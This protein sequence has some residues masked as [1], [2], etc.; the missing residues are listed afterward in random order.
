[1]GGEKTIKEVFQR[2]VSPVERLFIMLAENEPPFCNQLVLEGTGAFKA[3]LWKQAVVAACE[4]NPGSRLLL[5]GRWTWARWEDCG[6]AAPIRFV[7]GLSWS[8]CASDG[9]PFLLDPFPY[10]RGHTSEVLLV[11]GSPPRVVLRTLHATMDGGGTAM[12]GLDIF[13]ALRN[14]PLVG[15]P[16][17][18][19][20]RQLVE[21]LGFQ[22]RESLTT[23]RCL[24]PTGPPDGAALG[25]KWKRTTLGGRFSKLLPQLA[26]AVAR[27]ARKQGPGNVRITVPLD[28]RKRVPG[29]ASTANL[30]RRIFLDIPPEATV[31][32][33]ARQ[34]K[35]KL[36]HLTG[37]PWLGNL[38]V[39]LPMGWLK[40][41]FIASREKDRVRG[42]YKDSG[43]ISNLGQLPLDMFHGGGF[44]ARSCFFIPP[45]VQAK[46]FFITLSGCG[47][48][49]EMV[50]AM[51]CVLA[52]NGRLERFI[53]NIVSELKPSLTKYGE[54]PLAEFLESENLKEKERSL[55]VYGTTET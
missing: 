3:A 15:A 47:D 21:G 34:L 53:A 10:R 31:D 1:M 29:T 19:T 49:V 44:E 25:F 4:A 32:T 5:K 40:K 14:E 16:S 6:V 26:L 46:P 52:N 54:T 55:G 38:L 36:D 43:T 37:D 48:S 45:A 50:T 8:G 39:Y 2:K 35:D 30:T 24:T 18:I 51:P 12:W 41:L 13:R 28:L 9:A 22:N 33:I 42:F 23:A 20:D 17:P 27:E 11:S 7:D